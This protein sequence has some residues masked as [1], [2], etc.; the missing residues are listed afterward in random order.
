MYKYR[1]HVTMQNCHTPL[2]IDANVHVYPNAE[3]KNIPNFLCYTRA[4]FVKLILLDSAHPLFG[5]SI[6]S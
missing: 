5:K 1:Y 4:A 2:C 3:I 6:M